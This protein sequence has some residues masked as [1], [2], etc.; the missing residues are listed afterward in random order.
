MSLR[1]LLSS[2]SLY[3]LVV[4]SAIAA[5]LMAAVASPASAQAA[6]NGCAILIDTQS[7]PAGFNPLYLKKLVKPGDRV[8]LGANIPWQMKDG[9]EAIQNALANDPAYCNGTDEA[10]GQA[11]TRLRFMEGVAFHL[12][13]PA[14]F[15]TPAGKRLVIENAA[16][17][18]ILFSPASAWPNNLWG[19][20]TNPTNAEC[21]VTFTG[22]VEFRLGGAIGKKYHTTD[23]A[24]PL[25]IQPAFAFQF[26]TMPA[27]CFSGN[28]N[29]IELGEVY[30]IQAEYLQ[31]H[32]TTACPTKQT[33]GV[34][35]HGSDN[36]LID[37][38]VH[39]I[40][41][42]GI[43]IEKGKK[44][45]QFI[46]TQVYTID[47]TTL[48]DQYNDP[49]II[50]RGWQPIA[51]ADP[52]DGVTAPTNLTAIPTS[53]AN[54]SNPAAY[55]VTMTVPLGTTRVEVFVGAD[56]KAYQWS[57]P[58]EFP[59]DRKRACFPVDPWKTE[60]GVTI[61]TGDWPW[62]KLDNH[63]LVA[64]AHQV[65]PPNGKGV[66]D[67]DLAAEGTSSPYSQPVF[68]AVDANG[69]GIVEPCEGA[70]YSCFAWLKQAG[71]SG[72]GS[73]PPTP[74]GGNDKETATAPVDP[75][76]LPPEPTLPKNPPPEACPEGSGWDWAQNTCSPIVLTD[77]ADAATKDSSSG[78]EGG[79]NGVIPGA[80]G[81]NTA[82]LTLDGEVVD[83]SGGTP[84]DPVGTEENE[85]TTCTDSYIA[86]GSKA[87]EKKGWF[88][89][90]LAP[91]RG[92]GAPD[93]TAFLFLGLFLATCL[94]IL[95]AYRVTAYGRGSRG[96]RRRAHG[97]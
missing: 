93:R 96:D 73:A 38:K 50:L 30:A 19:A 3:A 95:S 12:T 16:A 77:P 84:G 61:D 28:D 5:V 76:K 86:C 39:G 1:G 74:A 80:G 90:S 13:K 60:V 29:V 55:A 22:D 11:I 40:C 18:G 4:I 94:S 25:I 10:T 46:R 24:T 26:F 32:G 64:T 43:W 45:N 51:Y 71:Q 20:F 81:A 54:L 75:E 63:Y 58:W 65:K 66:C 6:T 17:Q 8:K 52:A 56:P 27:L 37:T 9:W 62:E 69:D 87:S 85:E 88:G 97:V 23:L 47:N 7:P 15:Q 42:H 36:R 59:R 72:G 34:R 44:K 92:K 21:A 70:T 91:V 33:D 83:G 79:F 68:L 31:L 57:Y 35:I 53:T 41:G 67:A 82:L 14:T 78:G 48:A 2:V 49:S 89:C